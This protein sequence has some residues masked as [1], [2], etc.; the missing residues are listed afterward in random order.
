MRGQGRADLSAVIVA[1]MHELRQRRPRA[2]LKTWLLRPPC[3]RVLDE[4]IAVQVAG[5]EETLDRLC[6]MRD[7]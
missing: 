6:D 1:V 2:H 4:P 5:R 3:R 7:V